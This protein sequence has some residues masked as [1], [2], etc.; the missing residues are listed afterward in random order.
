M[1]VF[2]TGYFVREEEMFVKPKI[3]T[4]SYH[5]V[6]FNIGFSIGG[7][8]GEGGKKRLSTY[9]TKSMQGS[10]SLTR[11]CGYGRTKIAFVLVVQNV[12][13]RLSSKPP[14]C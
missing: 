11:G 13:W 1:A 6:H 12:H 7:G 8:R 5:Y 3:F 10:L 14:H 9:R 4:N 2:H